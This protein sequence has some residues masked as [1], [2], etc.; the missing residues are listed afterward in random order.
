MATRAILPLDTSSPSARLR[1]TPAFSSSSTSTIGERL[2][3]ATSA[4][5]RARDWPPESMQT[6]VSLPKGSPERSFA[7]STTRAT[8]ASGSGVRRLAAC[9]S[10]NSPTLRSTT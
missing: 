6:R 4:I 1:S 9:I 2:S 7:S 10:R 8:T 3:S 5:M